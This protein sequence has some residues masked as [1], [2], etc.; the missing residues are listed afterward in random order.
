MPNYSYNHAVAREA[1]VA[2]AI[3]DDPE[4]LAA[5]S[6]EHLRKQDLQAIVD[7]A[8]AA[9]EAN[10]A[11]NQ[12]AGQADGTGA[13]DAVYALAQA[14]VDLRRRAQLAAA[15]AHEALESKPK[16]K[17]AKDLAALAGAKFSLRAKRKKKKAAAVNG[18]AE[19]AGGAPVETPAE[20]RHSS[21]SADSVLAEVGQYTKLLG[22]LEALAPFLKARGV[23][24]KSVAKLRAQAK[25]VQVKKGE[26]ISAHAAVH[27]ATADEH[28]A[29]AA[30]HRAWAKIAPI[31][32]GL[33]RAN[34]A[35]AALLHS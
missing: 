9:E 28:A 14:L 30:T 20:N 1:R 22:K 24:P 35:I 31:L 21:R 8:T 17:L 6:A 5:I 4:L 29:V 18:D 23:D 16:K 7:A 34:P 11:Q 15:D 3:L 2:G 10:I 25:K 12:A 26:S 33:G 19:A 32:H 27:L 13:K